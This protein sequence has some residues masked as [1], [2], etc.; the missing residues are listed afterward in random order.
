MGLL[1]TVL[2]VPEIPLECPTEVPIATILSPLHSVEHSGH[3][4]IVRPPEFTLT[5][6][7]KAPPIDYF[8]GE[9]PAMISEDCLPSLERAADWNGWTPHDKVIQL[10]GY[11]KGRALQEWHLLS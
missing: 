4:T 9:D 2:P 6:R 8:S 11:L 3:R 10:P 7:G 5:R 1:I